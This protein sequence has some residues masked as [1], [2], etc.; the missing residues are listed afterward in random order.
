[1]KSDAGGTLARQ[2]A[3][4]RGFTLI[5]VVIVVLIVGILATIAYPSYQE[6]IR[7]SRRSDAKNSLMDAANRQ[8]Q[9]ML[10][11]LGYTTDMR[12]LGFAANP[13]VSEDGYYSIS[14]AAGACGAIA[15]CYTLTAT[16]VAG[17]SQALDTKCT[18][19]AVAST[20]QRTGAGSLGNE[21][22]Q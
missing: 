5:E 10:D 16:P 20:G 1:M 21:C 13:A 6:Q 4:Q 22:W 9:Y 12:N 3:T 14:A 19:F 7:K 18:S 2:S 11:H 15:R 17:K 8:E